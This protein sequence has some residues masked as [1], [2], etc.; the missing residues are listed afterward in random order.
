MIELMVCHSFECWKSRAQ[1]QMPLMS[2]EGQYSW[3]A[4]SQLLTVPSCGVGKGLWSQRWVGA[5]VSVRKGLW[6]VEKK[7]WSQLGRNCGLS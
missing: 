2:I 5:V 7:L 4:D 3:F 6:S 1:V